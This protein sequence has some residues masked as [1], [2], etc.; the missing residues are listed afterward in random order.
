LEELEKNGWINTL[1]KLFTFDFL[2]NFH[3]KELFPSFGQCILAVSWLFA[4]IVILLP[5]LVK[6][7]PYF[8]GKQSSGIE[9]YLK[10][11]IPRSNTKYKFDSDEQV[12]TIAEKFARNSFWPLGDDAVRWIL[13]FVFF[14][15][16][17]ILLPYNC[18]QAIF[19][20]ILALL[21]GTIFLDLYKFVLAHV[22]RNLVSTKNNKDVIKTEINQPGNFGIGILIGGE[23]ERNTKV[24]GILNESTSEE[25]PLT[26]EKIIDLLAEIEQL[27]R[28]S[29][30]LP[31][32]EKE[33]SLQY[34]GTAKEEAKQTE[35]DKDLIA[36]SL[37]RMAETLKTTSETVA[38]T[39]TLWDSVKPILLALPSWLGVAKNFLGF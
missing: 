24:A 4:F 22:S 25:K 15:L 21:S 23:I 27:I 2:S 13:Y 33:K 20:F 39:K 17:T 3:F 18:N 34:L 1:G 10:E 32:A 7:L 38:S 31:E 12:T 16:Y 19:V 37:K 30:E 5:S 36:K 9:I 35:P 28:K 29:A 8:T 14:V 11:F 26:Q 6:F